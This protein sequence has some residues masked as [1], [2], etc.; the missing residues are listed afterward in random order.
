[1]ETIRTFIAIPLPESIL[2]EFEKL[3]QEMRSLF[4]GVK[5][6]KPHSIHLTLKFL[7]NLPPQE[8]QKVFQAMDDFFQTPVHSFN[9]TVGGQGAFPNFK[10]PRVLWVGVQG[11]GLDALKSLQR[12]LEEALAREGFEKE[13]RAFSPHLTV[14]RI[15]YPKNLTE[16]VESFRNFPFPQM[17]FQADRV[18]IM[19]SQLRPEGAEYSVQ[20]SYELI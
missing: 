15:K 16:L 5:W 12:D 7:G 20:K 14:G 13:D 11:S 3:Y 8:L 10:R 4:P 18:H 9:L 17:E 1:M 2:A 6:V 19:R